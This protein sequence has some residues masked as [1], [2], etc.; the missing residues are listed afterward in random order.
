MAAPA[1][2]EKLLAIAKDVRAG[3]MATRTPNKLPHR[4]HFVPSSVDK[5]RQITVQIYEPKE[6][7]DEHSGPVVINL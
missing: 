5:S 1:A 2:Y 3:R 6:I 7:S 4:E